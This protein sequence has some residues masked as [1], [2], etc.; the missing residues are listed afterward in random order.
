MRFLFLFLLFSSVQLSAQYQL[1]I[2]VGISQ[3]GFNNFTPSVPT[4]GDEALLYIEGSQK[5]FTTWQVACARQLGNKS[6][7]RVGT[8]FMNGI[9]R[10]WAH[11]ISSDEMLVLNDGSYTKLGLPID[12]QYE[13]LKFVR[14]SGGIAFNQYFLK[15]GGA[16]SIDKPIADTYWTEQQ[17]ND[18]IEAIDFVRTFSTEYR[19]GV[20]FLPFRKVTV[21]VLFS[22]T[23]NRM[24]DNI[25]YNGTDQNP[26]MKY[27]T[28]IF[29]LGYVIDLAK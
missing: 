14:V 27:R 6:R 4:L 16:I 25:S 11:E 12:F 17:Q 8:E 18:I 20:T 23:L 21:D 9:T 3:T 13:L 1:E 5:A 29:R 24:N 28:A 15:Q 7:L 19:Y 2:G 22:G 26:N 10:V